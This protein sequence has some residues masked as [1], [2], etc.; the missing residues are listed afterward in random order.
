MTYDVRSLILDPET[1]SALILDLWSG[2]CYFLHMGKPKMYCYSLT[3]SQHGAATSNYPYYC[4][5]RYVAR[6]RADGVLTWRRDDDLTAGYRSPVKA[7][8]ESGISAYR[9]LR[10]RQNDPVTL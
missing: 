1:I 8:R 7:V 6:P 3:R 9:I 4:I 5:A 2:V 10:V